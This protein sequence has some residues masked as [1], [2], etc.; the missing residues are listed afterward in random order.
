MAANFERLVRFQASDGQIYYGEAGSDWQSNLKGKE[1]QLF[2]GTDPFDGGFHLTEK[3]AV[4]SEVSKHK[5]VCTF[6]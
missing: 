3:K 4:V 5:W 6:E 1:I 2:S